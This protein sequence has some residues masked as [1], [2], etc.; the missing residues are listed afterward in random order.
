VSRF[1]LTETIIVGGGPSGMM[2]AL[3]SS[4]SGS[5]VTILEHSA[6]P[7]NKLLLS[8]GGRCNFTHACEARDIVRLLGKRGRFIGHALAALD[9]AATRNL[10]ARLGVPSRIEADGRVVPVS[11]RAT[12]VR[13][14]LTDA[15]SREG[16]RIRTGVDVTGIERIGDRW[17]ILTAAQPFDADRV[18]LATGG[19]SFPSTGSDGSGYTLARSIGHSVVH[20][21]P[22]EVPL[23]TTGFPLDRLQ[24]LTVEGVELSVVGCK[25][26]RRRGNVLFTHFGLS[27]PAVLDISAD[28]AE[29]LAGGREVTLQINLLPDV[30]E[31]IIAQALDGGPGSLRRLM[32]SRLAALV[33]ESA[34]VANAR[35]RVETV[36]CLKVRIARTRG[37][38]HAMVTRGGVSLT[39]V[40]PATMSSRLADG[41]Y[42]AGE[43]LDLDGPM[44]GFN[45]QMAWS[46]GWLAGRSA[47]ARGT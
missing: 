38:D 34:S 31:D 12:D 20:P 14:A 3:S 4:L 29:L 41:L 16:A 32:P 22:G 15:L 46:T 39:E 1:A 7:G 8:G 13:L 43:L 25:L 18:V 36:R 40:D 5:G 27:G 37:F 24:G 6:A 45:L 19:M 17:R 35:E 10:F 26:P 9:P 2:A 33:H 44:G 21:V 30:D 28:V 42:F 23:L 11:E 47:A